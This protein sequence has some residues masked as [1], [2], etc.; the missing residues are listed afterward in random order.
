[1]G[2]SGSHGTVTILE[3]ANGN[4]P[5]GTEAVEDDLKSHLS[6]PAANIRRVSDVPPLESTE[7]P[8]EVIA[9]GTVGSKTRPV[10]PSVIIRKKILVLFV[11]MLK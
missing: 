6:L 9:E 2:C 8:S 7:P 4:A 5:I 3:N 1:M 11:F 10:T